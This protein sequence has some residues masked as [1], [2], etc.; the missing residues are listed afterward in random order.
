M[1]PVYAKY[2]GYDET[3]I[4]YVYKHDRFI[5]PWPTGGEIIYI[6]D[7]DNP[8]GAEIEY[9]DIEKLCNTY[10]VVILD[11]AYSTI[12]EIVQYNSLIAEFSNLYMLHS[13]SKLYGAAGLRIGVVLSNPKNIE[14]LYE[15]KPMYELSAMAC[16]YIEFVKDNY[17]EY[18]KSSVRLADSKKYIENQLGNLSNVIRTRGNFVIVEKNDKITSVIGNTVGYKELTIDGCNFIRITAPDMDLAKTLFNVY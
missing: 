6:A 14:L 15:K 17:I 3:M 13:F 12:G 2:F 16:T 1:V 5:A 18:V 7:P 10:G 8:T 9:Q 11:K 4:N